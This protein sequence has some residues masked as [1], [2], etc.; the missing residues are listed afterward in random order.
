MVEVEPL[1]PGNGA[2]ELR[3]RPPGKSVVRITA[4]S[5]D[6]KEEWNSAGSLTLVGLP[7]GT[8]KTKV[9]PR[10]GKS[11][12]STFEV[13]AGQSCEL[14][15]DINAGEEWVVGPCSEAR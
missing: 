10:D 5:G 6:Y 2:V 3:V 13:K 15:L 7:A 11:L 4:V 9:S 8:Y 1:G 12:R 14:T